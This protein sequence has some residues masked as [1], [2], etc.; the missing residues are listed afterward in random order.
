MAPASTPTSNCCGTVPV[1]AVPSVEGRGPG[2]RRHIIPLVE[3]RNLDLRE[4]EGTTSIGGSVLGIGSMGLYLWKR[5]PRL[6]GSFDEAPWALKLSR[7][8]TRPVF[9]G[10]SR[11]R[12][13]P[14]A[15]DLR[16]PM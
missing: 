11:R 2:D 6:H 15:S 3:T 14:C 4:S 9:P 1:T 8:L 12:P 7:R 13:A 5:H 16:A 10:G